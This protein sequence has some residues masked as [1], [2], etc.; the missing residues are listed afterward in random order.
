[1]AREQQLRHDSTSLNLLGQAMVVMLER[2]LPDAATTVEEGTRNLAEHF[3]QLSSQVKAQDEVIK[4]LMSHCRNHVDG[5]ELAR[6]EELTT[7]TGKETESCDRAMNGIVT[8]MQFQD[9]HSQEMENIC[10]VLNIYGYLLEQEGRQLSALVD[11]MWLEAVE[12]SML[13]AI[14]LTDLRHAL[15]DAA[16]Q[17][18]LPFPEALLK[19]AE[20]GDDDAETIEL[21]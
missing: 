20:S 8:E 15:L 11:M 10:T 19:Q 16:R 5:A 18:G 14:R 17:V 12:K 21:F 3:A 2:L 13:S 9:R 1:M 7:Q 4:Q 6:L